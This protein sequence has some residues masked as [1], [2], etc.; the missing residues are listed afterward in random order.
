MFLIYF[1]AVF[2]QQRE[3]SVIS[4]VGAGLC[5]FILLSASWVGHSLQRVQ[6]RRPPAVTLWDLVLLCGQ[7]TGDCCIAV[8]KSWIYFHCTECQV[9][10]GLPSKPPVFSTQQGRGGVHRQPPAPPRWG[11]GPQVSSHVDLRCK[12]RN[13]FARKLN[14]NLN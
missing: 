12:M 2:N 9:L 13:W 8:P 7:A 5:F 6:L 10:L 3:M 14:K 11:I 1:F 4:P